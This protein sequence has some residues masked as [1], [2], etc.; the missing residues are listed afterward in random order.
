[1]GSF[2][3]H[4][5]WATAT[6]F[7]VLSFALWSVIEVNKYTIANPTSWVSVLWEQLFARIDNSFLGIMSGPF[8]F[9]V[10]AVLPDIDL[11]HSRAKG[12]A[13]WGIPIFVGT[14]SSLVILPVAYS[15][16][17]ALEPSL[18]LGNWRYLMLMMIPVLVMLLTFV[19][20]LLV[21][22][23]SMHWGKVHS[24]GAAL[25]FSLVLLVLVLPVDLLWS[26]I[27]ALCLFS[28]Y[29]EH[30]LVDQIY[31]ELRLKEWAVD[32][33]FALKLW[34]NS[35]RFDPLIILFGMS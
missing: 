15:A 9:I 18:Q 26:L 5:G 1:M 7:L 34:S 29:V 33:R 6:L 20:V 28:G 2:S 12:L 14:M 8:T 24:I 22:R 31:H 17:N 13:R 35:W 27:L 10:G 30:L 32:D 3:Q 23:L 19:L 21:G 4:V 25:I 11:R 16:L